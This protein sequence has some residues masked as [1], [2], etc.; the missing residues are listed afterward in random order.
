MSSPGRLRTEPRWLAVLALATAG[1]CGRAAEVERPPVLANVLLVTIDTLRADH[2]GCYGYARATTP[3]LDELAGEGLR[4]ADASTPRAKTTPAIASLLTGL[5]PHAHGV[6]DLTAPLPADGPVLLQERLGRAGWRTAAIVGN[7]VLTDE[8]SGLARGFDHWIEELPDVRGVPPHDAPQRLARS[9]TDAALASLDDLIAAEP[10]AP[11]FLWLHYM[12]PH[13][14]YEPPA[15]HRVFDPGQPRWVPTDDELP[16]SPLHRSKL[17]EYNVPP[18]AQ[19]ADGRVDAARV[20]ALYDGEVRYVDAQL[21]RLFAHLR[22]AG[23]L[24]DT[25][26]IVTADHGESLGEH[27]YWFEHGSYAYQATCRVPLLVR[28]PEALADLRRG[29]FEAPVSLTDLFST[30]LEA[31]ALDDPVL[32]DPARQGVG[33]R[34]RSLLAACRDPRAE[35]AE[36]PVFLE[37]VERADLDRAVQIKAA[38]VGPWKLVRRYAHVTRGGR[39]ELEVLSEELF[40]LAED[41]LEARDLAGAPPADAPLGELR[42]RLL[43]FAA[44]DRAFPELDRILREQRE[45]L[46]RT[47]PEALRV[48]EALGY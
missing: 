25:L 12:D 5:Y 29:V 13:G 17:A 41:P 9:L 21:G 10:S 16:P 38:R 6:R 14:T 39:R 37:K 36:R 34:G 44:A 35:Q 3:N 32:D 42:A 4:F 48:L 7:W 45:A 20:V 28:W 2:L 19:A 43:A 22:A 47:D 27:R 31:L 26:V 11:F 1:A 24:D 18:E 23:A 33:P 8:R 40:D 46:E 15:E 30:V